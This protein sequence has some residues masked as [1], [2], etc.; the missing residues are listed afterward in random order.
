MAPQAVHQSK[1]V[2]VVVITGKV[3]Q[4]PELRYTAAG[5]A[6]ATIRVECHFSYV[7]D[8][9]RRV[10]DSEYHSVKATGELAISCTTWVQQGTAIS[11]E[12]HLKTRGWVQAATGRTVTRT[13][14]LAER[15][16][17]LP[18]VPPKQLVQIVVRR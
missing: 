11:I 8:E 7:N 3:L 6:V 12:A 18:A 2:N 10:H 15:I 13:E 9:G 4:T 17:E 14:I 5:R 1:Y 16:I